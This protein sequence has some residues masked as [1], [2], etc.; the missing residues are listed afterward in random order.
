[1]STRGGARH[2][3]K[4]QVDTGLLYKSICQNKGPLAN[5]GLYESISKTQACNPKALVKVIPLIKGLVE[6]EATGE[7][8]GQ[9]LR[10]AIF[11]LMEDPSL[12]DSKWAGGT[13][14]SLRVERLNVVLFHMRRLR[15]SGDLRA[16]ASKLTTVEFLQIQEV[17]ELMEKKPDLEEVSALPLVQREEPSP[18][19]EREGPNELHKPAKKLKVSTSDVSVDSHG[20][21]KMFGTP[22][23]S[24]AA[25]PASS[26]P[27]P[28]GEPHEES[29]LP[30][31]E[32]S[33][34]NSLPKG[35]TLAKATAEPSF[36]W[37]QRQAKQRSRKPT[38][39]R[40]WALL[41]PWK[42]LPRKRQRQQAKPKA[43]SPCQKGVP[44]HQHTL[45]KNGPSSGWPKAARNHVGHTSQ[46]Q[47]TQVA[48]GSFPWLWKP[49]TGTTPSTWKF[50]S[51]SRRSWRK[52]TWQKWRQL[53]WGSNAMTPGEDLLPKEWLGASCKTSWQKGCQRGC[54]PVHQTSWQK[55]HAKRCSIFLLAKEVV[56]VFEGLH[57]PL[58]KRG[59]FDSLDSLVCAK[60]MHPW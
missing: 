36:R 11:Q 28:K 27:L 4:P 52:T 44:A 31:G 43:R 37:L 40:N 15:L 21:P 45:E 9:N 47:Q 56:Q 8:H 33:E 32:P 23:P 10:Q 12:N 24:A 55:W 14:V 41:L 42:G 19:V 7:I 50:W 54:K 6:L 30:K 48:R 2:T 29:P 17:V 5:M 51:T 49:P 34:P 58:A 13:W 35:K 46:A 18:L 3:T 22:E 38:W 53:S 59:E 57:K 1:M 39:G 16:C 60:I 20:L 26:K 25:S